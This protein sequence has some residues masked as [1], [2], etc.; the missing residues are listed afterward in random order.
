MLLNGWGY[1]RG[2]GDGIDGRS[3]DVLFLVAEGVSCE[4]LEVWAMVK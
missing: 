2:N 4:T 1:G 3:N